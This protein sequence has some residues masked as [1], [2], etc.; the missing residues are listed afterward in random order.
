MRRGFEIA[1]AHQLTIYDSL[2]IS[3]ALRWGKL[4]TSDK[5]QEE[6]ARKLGVEVFYIY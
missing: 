1:L 3:Q 4:L 5:L 6:V 2:Y